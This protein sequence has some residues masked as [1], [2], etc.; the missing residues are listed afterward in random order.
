VVAPIDGSPAQ[1]ASLRPGDIILK[2]DGKEIAK[3][4]LDE[5]VARIS[6]RKGTPVTLTLLSPQSG[7]TREVTVV[8]DAIKIPNVTWQRLPGTTAGHL[9]V[10]RFHEG[11]TAQLK[12]VLRE[13]EAEKLSGVILD[14]RS[15]PGGLLEEAIGT[16]S[17]FLKGGNVLLQKN[18]E[19]Q[20][21]PVPVQ[22]ETTFDLPMVVLINS[23]TASAAEI[24]AGALQDGRRAVLVGEKTF[25]AGTVL[26]EFHL[27]DGSELLL[28]VEEW[29]TPSG[30]AIWHKG[31]VPNIVV[32][33]SR[34][35]APLLPNAERN[36]TPD[37]LRAS[38]DE[39]LLRALEVLTGQTSASAR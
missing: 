35:V 32:P 23:G 12:K 29:L 31:I 26:H 28:A 24:V 2:V 21:M 17:Q 5:V 34:E 27:S 16:A 25:G 9:R 15:N 13:I 36:L 7:R 8:R 4:T 14:L 10:A 11:L 3:L 33:L 39:Q 18:A 20:I 38:R 1:Q 19:G 6:G 37:E 30:Q 22:T